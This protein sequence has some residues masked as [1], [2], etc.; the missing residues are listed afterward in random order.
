MEVLNIPIIK[1]ASGEITNAP[2]LLKAAMSGKKLIISTGM[3]TLGE[4]ENA[5]GVVAFGYKKYSNAIVFSKSDFKKAYHS[6]EGQKLLE[7]NVALLHCTSSYPPPF[8]EI[9]LKAI[10]TLKKCFR[11]V[12]IQTIRKDGGGGSSC[13]LGAKIIEKHITLD[14]NLQGPDHKISR[15]HELADG[16][17]NMSGGKCYCKAIKADVGGR[18]YQ[19]YEKKHCC[20]TGYKKRG[21]FYA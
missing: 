8:N 15:A 2:L 14:K 19:A 3:S 4:I 18:K 17:R 21:I 13:C 5:L 16:K 20:S 9:N 11:V 12:H 7:E 6:E 1:I 10:K